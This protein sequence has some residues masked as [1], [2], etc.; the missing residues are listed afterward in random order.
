MT[1]WYRFMGYLLPQRLVAGRK[2]TRTV[3]SEASEGRGAEGEVARPDRGHALHGETGL[4]Q[5][6]YV[7]SSLLVDSYLTSCFLVDTY[8]IGH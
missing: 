5:P 4:F 7:M 2:C 1:F 6:T 8:L 3:S